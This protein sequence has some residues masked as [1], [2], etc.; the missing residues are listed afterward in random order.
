MPASCPPEGRA[1]LGRADAD[2]AAFW[3]KAENNELT[4]HFTG[5]EF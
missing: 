1:R 5:Q 3:G 4:A 2:A